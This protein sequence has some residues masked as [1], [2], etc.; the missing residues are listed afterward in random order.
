MAALQAQ[1]AQSEMI[2][3]PASQSTTRPGVSPGLHQ[4]PSAIFLRLDG[5]EVIPNAELRLLCL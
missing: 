4:R 5:K 2:T 1:G 3:V